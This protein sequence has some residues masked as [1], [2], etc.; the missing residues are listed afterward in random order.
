ML[1]SALAPEAEAPPAL[2]G[3]ERLA[4]EEAA[5]WVDGAVA[6]RD[7]LAL[8]LLAGEA[9]AQRGAVAPALVEGAVQSQAARVGPAHRESL[10]GGRAR[11]RFARR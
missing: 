1:V 4:R 5:G 9:V 8:A 11:M 10:C 3:E 6:L 2:A 7:L